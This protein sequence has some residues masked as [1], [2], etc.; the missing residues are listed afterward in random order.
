VKPFTIRSVLA[1]SP[2]IAKCSSQLKSRWNP[3]AGPAPVGEID[4]RLDEG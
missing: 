2:G 3:T 4:P 1:M